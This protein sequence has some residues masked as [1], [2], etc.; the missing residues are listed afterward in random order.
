MFSEGTHNTQSGVNVP[1]L[2][3]QRQSMHQQLKVNAQRIEALESQI[4]ATQMLATL[5]TQVYQVAHEFNNILVP[6][7]N[8]S[9]LALRHQDDTDL[10]R[11]ALT[12]TIEH[13]NK[14]SEIIQCLLGT[15]RNQSTPFQLCNINELVQSTL[16]CISSEFKKDRID[17]SV[18]IEG[19]L[20]C[21]MHSG[22]IQ[23]VLLNL[24]INAKQAMH[25][26]GGTLTIEAFS[27]HDALSIIVTDTGCG[28]E[29]N[30]LSKIFDP[31]VSTKTE[32]TAVNQLGTGLGLVICKDIIESHS[33]SIS[34]SSEINKGTTFTIVIPQTKQVLSKNEDE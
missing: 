10:M 13:G 29:Q 3:N 20:A 8:Y 28:I 7:I 15:I 5:G 26:H 12:K 17:A 32:E 1:S 2:L 31:F 19:D 22:Q 4:K 11:K 30:I 16:K 27:K 25:H 14:A 33:G 24:F 6:M 21:H 34:V 9:E 23:Q 18:Q